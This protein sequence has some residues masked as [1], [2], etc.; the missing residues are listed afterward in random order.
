MQTLSQTQTHT[1]LEYW[2]PKQKD[3]IKLNEE[4][5]NQEKCVEEGRKTKRLQAQLN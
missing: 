5:K 2:N 4:E 1:G 3:V